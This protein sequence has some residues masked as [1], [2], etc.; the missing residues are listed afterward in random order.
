MNY[1]SETNSYCYVG[2]NKPNHDIVIIGWD[3]SYPKENFNSN[4]ENDGAF[5]CR[6]SWGAD[7]GNNGNFYISYYDTNIGVHNVVYTKVEDVD[8][9]DN[10]YQTDLCGYIGQLGYNKESSYFANAYTAVEDEDLLAVGFYATGVDTEYSIYVCEDF[11]DVSSLAK[12]S[13]P[14]MTGKLK[15]SGY[16]TIKLDNKIKLTAGKKYAII[17]RI[18]TPNSLRPVAVEY[19]HNSQTANVDITDG[20]GY[21]SLKGVN[22]ESTEEVYQCN[23][24]LKAYTD[25]S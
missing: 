10:I 18:N 8:N 24:C 2:S 14:V 20:E 6:N 5:I 21:V 3:D 7:F 16:Y 4:V 12:R 17:V 19:A 1:N 22:W 23:V 11:K 9:Y 25:N 15:N 13:N